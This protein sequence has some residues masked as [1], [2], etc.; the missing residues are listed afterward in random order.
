M[1]INGFW[2]FIAALVVFAIHAGFWLH[3]RR[4]YTRYLD[5]CRF[6]NEQNQ[7]RHNE[8]VAACA[9]LERPTV[10]RNR[11]GWSSKRGQA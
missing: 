6:Y 7:R 10:Y 8:F 1:T 2:F 4:D 5:W 9:A 11:L 3:W